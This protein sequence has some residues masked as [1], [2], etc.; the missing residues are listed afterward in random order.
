MVV[1]SPLN[2]IIFINK[3]NGGDILLSLSRIRFYMSMIEGACLL[4]DHLLD[5]VR[6]SRLYYLF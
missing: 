6:C 3:N 2:A 5:L 1:F 4:C